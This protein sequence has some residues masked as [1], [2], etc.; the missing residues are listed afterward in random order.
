MCDT[1]IDGW[2]R[3]AIWYDCDLYLQYR[4]GLRFRVEHERHADPQPDHK[5]MPY[6]R[7][8]ETLTSAE[9]NK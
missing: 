4:K 8:N 5:Q 2:R 7:D 9:R 3:C 6:G 1:S